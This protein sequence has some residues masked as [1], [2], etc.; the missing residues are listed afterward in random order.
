MPAASAICSTFLRDWNDPVF[1]GLLVVDQ[2]LHGQR[3]RIIK[4][5]A[6]Y[7]NSIS[8][9]PPASSHDGAEAIKNFSTH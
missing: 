5:E 3:T 2:R 8:N 6:K 9:S 7:V 1:R 4:D